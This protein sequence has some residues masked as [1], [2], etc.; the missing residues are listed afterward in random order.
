AHAHGH[1]HT[2]PH[3]SAPPS[4]RPAGSKSLFPPGSSR[5]KPPPGMPLELAERWKAIVDR[6]RTID[7]A[8]YFNMLELARDST[9]E[10]AEEA[11][12]AMAKK[13]HPDRL[14][15]E[16]GPIREACSRVFS[17]MSEAHAT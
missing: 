7:R 1:G 4:P 16:L 10:E 13:W 2:Q 9:P 8:D 15:L 3:S 5:S 6:A 11:F 12:Y 17:R 14:P